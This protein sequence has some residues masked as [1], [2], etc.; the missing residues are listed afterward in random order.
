MTQGAL[1]RVVFVIAGAVKLTLQ[2][3]RGPD[4]VERQRYAVQGLTG[5]TKKVL[6]AP[7]DR[8]GAV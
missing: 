8:G 4:L 3:G 1:R 2:L 6:I 5:M 7:R